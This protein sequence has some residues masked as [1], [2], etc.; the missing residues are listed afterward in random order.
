MFQ[1]CTKLF[2]LMAIFGVCCVGGINYANA[3]SIDYELNDLG[4]NLFEYN[5]SVTNDT[6]VDGVDW[7]SIYFDYNLYSNLS[8][9]ASPAGWDSFVSEPKVISLTNRFDGF[10]DTF[11]VFDVIGFG[12]TLDGFSVSFE[13]LGGADL[14]AFQPYEV[15]DINFNVIES[16]LTLPAVSDVSEVPLPGALLF[17]FTGL[18]GLGFMRHKPVTRKL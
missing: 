9:T 5:Y 4:G 17:M 14:P 12:E 10:L 8:L 3:I 15:F 6:I 18:L 16:G 13:W 11:T 1:C 7:F 2:R